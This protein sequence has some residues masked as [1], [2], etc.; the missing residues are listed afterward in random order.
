MNSDSQFTPVLSI[1]IRL[2]WM[3]F[4]PT[5]LL[6]LAIGSAFKNSNKIINTSHIVFWIV[7]I[8]I[9][10]IRYI[11]IRYFNGETKDF[12]PSTMLH[13]KKYSIGLPIYAALTWIFSILMYYTTQIFM[14][15]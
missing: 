9:I 1:V 6:F 15:Y 12:E 10:A 8:A 2:C 11:D 13:L 5:T 14:I 3:Y 4:G 7:V